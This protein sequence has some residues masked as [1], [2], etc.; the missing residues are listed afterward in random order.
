MLD[1]DNQVVLAVVLAR[2]QERRLTRSRVA[3]HKRLY[4]LDG[5]VGGH[6]L[7]KNAHFQSFQPECSHPG[8]TLLLQER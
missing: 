4:G 7:I 8:Y 3:V 1:G 5:L 2:S 6:G